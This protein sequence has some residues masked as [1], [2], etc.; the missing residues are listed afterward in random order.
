MYLRMWKKDLS[1]R[2]KRKKEVEVDLTDYTSGG[3]VANY[4]SNYS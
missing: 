3:V 1:L 4:I 2:E